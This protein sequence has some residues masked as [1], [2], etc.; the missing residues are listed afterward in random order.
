MN[1]EW[2]NAIYDKYIRYR[3]FHRQTLLRTQST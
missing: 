1:E 3:T 2:R